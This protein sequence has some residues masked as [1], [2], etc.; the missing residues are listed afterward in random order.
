M[1]QL[2]NQEIAQRVRKAMKDEASALC[3]LADYSAG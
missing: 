1:K 3:Y 2:T